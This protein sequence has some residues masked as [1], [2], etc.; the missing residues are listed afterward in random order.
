M[1]SYIESRPDDAQVSEASAE[2][3]ALRD[4]LAALAENPEAE[5]QE[6]IRT[7]LE[8][9]AAS[10]ETLSGQPYADSVAARAARTVDGSAEAYHRA[11]ELITVGLSAAH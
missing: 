8:T 1:R 9:M 3:T 11:A 6:T 2:L 5:A 4:R 10:F 7:D